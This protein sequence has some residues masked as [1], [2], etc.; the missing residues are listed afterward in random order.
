MSK[1]NPQLLSINASGL[2]SNEFLN[3]SRK[4]GVKR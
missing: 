2:F 4:K 1:D 3:H